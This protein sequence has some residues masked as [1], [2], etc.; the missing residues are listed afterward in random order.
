G[1]EGGELVET[2][3]HVKLD[4]GGAVA[5]VAERDLQQEH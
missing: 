4:N 5:I 2:T 1:L 3:G